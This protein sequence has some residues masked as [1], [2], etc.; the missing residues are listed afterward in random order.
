[1]VAR[2][3]AAGA[4]RLASARATPA[5]LLINELVTNA[6]RHAFP[7]GR[8]GTLHVA[9]RPIEGDLL[10]IVIADDGI[11]MPAAFD[12]SRPGSLRLDL[13]YTFADQLQATVDFEPDRGTRFA[14]CFPMTVALSSWASA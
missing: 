8:A 3:A 6:L 1:R 9:V 13:V 11:G 7:A 14:L 5:G 2:D 10:E 4:A 12:P